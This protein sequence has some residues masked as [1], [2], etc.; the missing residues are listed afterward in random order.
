MIVCC[1]YCGWHE[2]RAATPRRCPG[3]DRSGSLHDAT[4]DY[5]RLAAWIAAAK[6]EKAT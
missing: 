2:E 5:K 1:L 4:E 6:G 3:C